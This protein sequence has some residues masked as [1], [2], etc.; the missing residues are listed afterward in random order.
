MTDKNWNEKLRLRMAEYEQTPPEGLWEA[1]EA[2]LPQQKAAAFPWMWALA[3]VA[4][5]VLAVVLLWRPA[6]SPVPADPAKLTA[7]VV[8]IAEPAPSG[9]VASDPSVSEPSDLS[10]LSTTPVPSIASTSAREDNA[11]PST[12]SSRTEIATEAPVPAREENGG[13]SRRARGTE[14]V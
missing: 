7:D 6:S 9:P 10:V 2:G 12:S 3:A 14:N 1:V 5:V 8:D 4:A 11:E 13:A